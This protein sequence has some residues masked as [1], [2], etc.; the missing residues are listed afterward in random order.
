VI[1]VVRPPQRQRAKELGA[2]HV[3]SSDDPALSA[4]IR[5]VAP[6]GINRIAEV[7]FSD[8][9]DL[10]ADVIATGGVI[11][12]YYSS[13]ER[14]SLPYW[15]LGFA[16]TTLRLLGSD[17]F[18]PAVKAHAARELTAALLDGSLRSEIA[19]RVPLAD[20]ARAHE[21]VEQGAGGRVIVTIAD[22]S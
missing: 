8:H 4:A 9:V 17:E 10:D 6:E 1:A 16:D 14:P 22:D 7:D 21:L 5:A 19:E 15:K 12:S 13:A 20:I 11:S 2:E 18:P 3:L